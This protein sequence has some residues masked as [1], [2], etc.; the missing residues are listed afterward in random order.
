MGKDNYELRITNYELRITNYELRITFFLNAN[1]A[2]SNEVIYFS[3]I[4]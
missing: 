3:L 4:I 2:M 1:S